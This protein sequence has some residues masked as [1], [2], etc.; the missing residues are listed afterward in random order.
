MEEIT[1]LVTFVRTA[2]AEGDREL[3][4]Y[5]QGILK[6][7]CSTGNVDRKRVWATLTESEQVAFT[8]L[9]K[10]ETTVKPEATVKA[11]ATLEQNYASRIGEAKRYKSS[12]VARAIALDLESDI[13]LGKTTEAAVAEIVGKSFQE[14]K[15][16]V[17]LIDPKDADKI[18]DIALI[19]WDE[20]Y[21]EQTQSLITQMFGWQ[22][23]GDKYSQ[24]IIA[25]WL[26][27]ED[28]LVRDRINQLFTLKNGKTD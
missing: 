3:A 15:I 9:V 8:A 1:E 18:R 7:A 28:E 4:R 17:E 13:A 19:W 2:I 5:I 6:E 22:S 14:F 26:E 11:E 16:L 20:Y 10:P 21:P 23:P 27:T 24:E 25:Q 12:A